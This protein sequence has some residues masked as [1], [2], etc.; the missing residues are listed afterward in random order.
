MVVPLGHIM[1]AF[2]IAVLIV[3][4]HPLMREALFTAITDQPGLGAVTQAGNGIEA[5]EIAPALHPDIILF[6]LGN[7]GL[8]DML[9]MEALHETWPRASILVL[10]SNEVEGQ[11]QAALKYGAQ[12]VVTKG[13]PREE[14]LK[15]LRALQSKA[16]ELHA[17][18]AKP[19]AGQE[20]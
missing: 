17:A 19:T 20:V 7:P 1:D 16:I 6:S 9:N 14:L 4:P 8:E 18:Q 5:L 15:A 2:S 3:E 11:E 10:T 13:A 12:A